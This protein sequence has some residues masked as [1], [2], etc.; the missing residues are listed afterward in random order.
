MAP[1]AV[2]AAESVLEVSE[3]RQCQ[4]A[5]AVYITRMDLD[6]LA[7]AWR[8][9]R[10]QEQQHRRRQADEAR[11]AARRAAYLLREEF[12]AREV[13]LFGSLIAGPRHDD[14]DV[15]LAV[16]GIAPERYFSALARVSD[17]VGRCVDLV[18]LETCGDRRRRRVFDSGERIDG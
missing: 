15:D 12:G 2:A 7:Q 16:S 13:W 18:P 11:T 5:A 6:T 3:D 1:A 4:Y 9:R 14:F 17:I 8:D 10:A